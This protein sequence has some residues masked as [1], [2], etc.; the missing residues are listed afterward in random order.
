MH[1]RSRA[2]WVLSS[3]AAALLA[4]TLVVSLRP[5]R[6][7]DPPREDLVRGTQIQ[8]L[9]PTGRIPR[10][11]PFVW[12][13]PVRADHFKVVVLDSSNAVVFAAKYTCTM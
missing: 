11:T 5:R 3:L 9:S 12:S 6:P 2:A 1:L 13:S 8:L 10:D 7:G 4:G